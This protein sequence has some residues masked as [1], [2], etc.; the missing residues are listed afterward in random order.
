MAQTTGKQMKKR[1][2]RKPRPLTV[3]L[4]IK[5]RAIVASVRTYG[6]QV[7]FAGLKAYDCEELS[8]WLLRAAAW[9]K[10]QEDK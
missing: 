2:L 3:P 7:N 4:Q 5:G 1:K 10:E 8:N 6:A 9:L